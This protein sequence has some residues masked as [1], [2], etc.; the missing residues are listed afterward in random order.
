MD[1]ELFLF[2]RILEYREAGWTNQAAALEAV[3][4]TTP[5]ISISALIMCLVFGGM[6]L[7]YISFECILG[8]IFAVSVLFDAFFV[9]AVLEPCALAIMHQANYW[10]RQLP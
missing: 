6:M 2:Q 7:G 10:P 9:R 5:T 8:F 4:V 3:A 1:Y